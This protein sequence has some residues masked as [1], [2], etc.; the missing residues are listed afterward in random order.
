M[1][2]SLSMDCSRAGEFFLRISKDRCAKN[3]FKIT[4]IK[5][6]YLYLLY[7]ELDKEPTEDF[8]RGDLPPRALRSSRERLLPK[9]GDDS[10]PREFLRQLF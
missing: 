8:L 4:L 2:Y 10:T 6:T 1:N 5:L 3:A 9:A 7:L